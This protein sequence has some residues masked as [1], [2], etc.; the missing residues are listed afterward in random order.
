[1]CPGM[2][3][4]VQGQSKEHVTENI[5]FIFLEIIPHFIPNQANTC[6]DLNQKFKS[7]LVPPQIHTPSVKWSGLL[8]E[9]C[10]IRFKSHSLCK[11]I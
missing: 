5:G 2:D 1:M 11:V 8:P 3:I 7:A 10:K 4:P 9:A 6:Q